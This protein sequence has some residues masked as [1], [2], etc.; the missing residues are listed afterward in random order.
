MKSLLTLALLSIPMG[1]SAQDFRL[2]GA[3]YTY[4]PKARL[5]DDGS[6]QQVSS[7]ESNVYFNIPTRLKNGKTILVNGL[8]FG[9]V[10][11]TSYSDIQSDGDK[12]N[13]YKIA[14][15]MML[16]HRLNEKWV[17]VGR[18]MPTLASDF[19]DKLNGD[20]FLMQGSFLANRKINENLLIGGGLVYG[21]R[22]GKPMLVPSVQVKYEKSRHLFFV[23]LPAVIDY[24][25]QLIR[26][27]RLRVGFKA[28]LNGAN[29]NSS[30]DNFTGTTAVDRL[31]YLTVNVGPVVRYRFAKIALLEVSSGLNALRRY[32]F[33]D[34]GNT[35]HKYS[36]KSS[37]FVSIGLTVV[38]PKRKPATQI[39]E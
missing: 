17:L 9:S 2:A 37:G 25:Y 13:F 20:D 15:T 10:R 11:T 29:F 8:Q 21:T 27:E 6:S 14:Y 19:D 3:D 35:L 7:Q 26:E 1:L 12:H 39:Q 30:V 38:P 5:K 18:L 32:Q 16:I 36:S 33:E 28:L 4:Y 22:L 34:A 23:F 31:N 24:S